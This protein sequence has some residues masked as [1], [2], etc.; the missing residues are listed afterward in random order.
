MSLREPVIER[1]V[2]PRSPVAVA[3]WLDEQIV[4]DASAWGAG[5]GRY[6]LRARGEGVWHLAIR[7]GN[8]RRGPDLTVA[9]ASDPDGGTEITLEVA[10][11]GDTQRR[12]GVVAATWIAFLIV[13]GFV[14]LSN[15][16]NGPRPATYGL[17]AGLVALVAGV[18]FAA[19]AVSRF[20][21]VHEARRETT[22]F[23]ESLSKTT[24]S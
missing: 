14:A 13:V 7:R 18:W 20:V 8:V 5:P 11:S 1:I 2:V 22:Y 10:P 19:R 21:A 9:V 16:E 3:L 23:R 6:F 17:F 12:N 4:R 15:V 24:R